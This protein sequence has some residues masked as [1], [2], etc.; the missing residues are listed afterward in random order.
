MARS[1]SER[2]RS[3]QEIAD[4]VQR[5][6]ADEKV[7]AYRENAREKIAR[8]TKRHRAWTQAAAVL[9]VAIATIST[10]AFLVVSRARRQEA[11]SR[12]RVDEQNSKEEQR[13][14]ALQAVVQNDVVA[15]Q[16]ALS[17]QD[18]D[19]AV[20][21][22]EGTLRLIHNE[23]R[24]AQ[25]GPVP[26][27]MYAQACDARSERNAARDAHERLAEFHRLHDDALFHGT[28]LS[29]VDL[30][31]D[32]ESARTAA[33]AALDLMGVPHEPGGAFERD[34]HYS[35][36]Q[37]R[38]LTEECQQLLL[39]LA[40]IES[41]APPGRPAADSRVRADLALKYLDIAA[42]LGPTGRAHSL[43][44]SEYL[45]K[46][47]DS[48]AAARARSEAERVQPS[49]A[50]DYFLLGDAMY[51]G[52]DLKGA[53]GAF[54]DALGKAPDNFWAHYFTAVCRLN[55]DRPA[56]AETS[57]TAC[58]AI[59][60]DFPW[61]YL[62][63]GYARGLLGEMAGSE[64]DFART[65]ELATTSGGDR[66]RYAVFVNQGRV[67][68][69]RGQLPQG[70]ADL[71]RAVA[72]KPDQSQGHANLAFGYQKQGNLDKA[73]VHLD[74]AITLAPSAGLYVEKGP[75]PGSSA[76]ISRPLRMTST[77]P[78]G[79]SV[80]T[81]RFRAGP[82]SNTWPRGASRR[83][84]VSSTVHWR[85]DPP[86]P[87]SFARGLARANL[88]DDPGAV[89]DYNR[90]LA[91]DADASNIRTR[92]GWTYVLNPDRLALADFERA[93]KLN[94]RNGDAHNGRG[95]VLARLGRYREAVED[96]E[97]AL[98][99]DLPSRR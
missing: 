12:R 20:E 32:H 9:L 30:L 85:R 86:M 8:W 35:D 62:L 21:R 50:T 53:L 49:G 97:K 99:L 57:L 37:N 38:R 43:R 92:R 88:G 1:R 4:E 3:A 54:R 47:G 91:L 72:L 33:M 41:R 42:A 39:I 98:A 80:R 44:R 58:L 5:W 17:A 36:D 87:I 70:I 69:L 65:L 34:P 2:Y 95:F 61:V 27:S 23:P 22:L 64:A 77:G 14:Q 83:P 63:R 75:G 78:Y 45:S 89:E 93:I 66:V 59:R 81:A 52:G 94:P 18:W 73:I 13:I 24:L 90:S 82:R 60:T 68:V 31:F 29:G 48:A 15:C 76:A 84:S 19:R 11:A 10:A 96:A 25:L 6:L 16:A 71:E 28:F 79:W 67:R 55:L 46:K 26:D 7:V 74:R 40:D 56:E 51:R